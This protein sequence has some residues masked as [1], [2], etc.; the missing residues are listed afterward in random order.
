MWA[1]SVGCG[2]G[3]CGGRAVHA[4]G[5]GDG[6]RGR[7][8][9]SVTGMMC[10]GDGD[11]GRGGR[12]RAALVLGHNACD[13]RA[14]AEAVGAAT[15]VAVVSLLHADVDGL[16]SGTSRVLPLAEGPWEGCYVLGGGGGGEDAAVCGTDPTAGLVA[17]LGLECVLC[18]VGVA[19]EPNLGEDAAGGRAVRAARRAAVVG[20]PTVAVCIPSASSPVPVAPACAA[21]GALLEAATGPEGALDVRE[22]AANCPR[23]H[24]PFPTRAR[25]AALGSAQLPVDEA[26][27]RT[28]LDAQGDPM[29]AEDC[30]S[31][32]ASDATQLARATMPS[33]A[34]RT[35]PDGLREVLRGAFREADVFLALHV[36]PSWE[37]SRGFSASRPG[38][39]WRQE[40]VSHADAE[41]DAEADAGADAEAEV[42]GGGT[43]DLWG[44][45]LPTQSLHDARPTDDGAR[46]VPQLATDRLVASS[47]ASPPSPIPRVPRGFV[48]GPGTVVADECTLGDVDA[49]L[50]GKAAVVTLP[51]WPQGHPFALLDPALVEALRPHP[52]TGMPLWLCCK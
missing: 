4:V 14:T 1:V 29:A 47:K 2:A 24:F 6:L 43:G 25:W 8:R 11:G 26:M 37:P 45:S 32:G 3:R 48:V 21:L 10:R 38:V 31:M 5:V 18:V 7:G 36:P 50:R 22:P 51:S 44:R 49:V 23:S 17:S 42:G 30:W 16:S 33:P 34:G 19:R 39:L 35:A 9:R 41:A 15:G 40:R 52:D 20:V 28:L 27:Q 12:P 46:F 13:V